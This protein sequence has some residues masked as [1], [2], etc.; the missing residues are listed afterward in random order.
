M[1]T[2]P[3]FFVA[4]LACIV[5]LVILLMGINSFRKGGVEGSKQSNKFMVWRLIAQFVAVVLIAA[6]VF[7][8][9][10]SGG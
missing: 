1:T 7:F 5:V 2:D 3:L 4:L 8:R 10:Q 9:G 6:F